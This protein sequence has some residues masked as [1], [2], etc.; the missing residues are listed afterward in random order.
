MAAADLPLERSV[1]PLIDSLTDHAIYRLDVDGRVASWNVGAE[2]LKGYSEAEIRGQ[3]FSRFF[4]LEDCRSR[5]PERLLEEAA[6]EGRVETEG[7]RIR[8]DGSR[9]WAEGVL[10]AVREQ[11]RLVG[12]AKITRDMTGH[13]AAQQALIESERRFRILVEGVLDYA[14]YM[15]DPDGIV[16]NWNRGA[17]R[18]KG[19]AARDV[20]GR[21]FSTFYTP[22]DREAG[23]PA[24]ALAT[25]LSR[26]SFEG[27]GWRLR[28]DGSRFWAMVVIHAV[29]DESGRHIGFAKVTRDISERKA[30]EEALAQSERQFR[31]L[32]GSVVDYAMVMLDPS[33][34]VTN[35]NA[36]AERIKG[37]TADEIVGQ[38]F[39][40]FYTEADRAAGAPNAALRCSREEGRYETE[41]WR[42]RRD[43]TQF[44]ASVVID[45]IR[46]ETGEVIGFAKITR[47]ITERRNAQLELDRAREKAAQGRKLEAL[48]QLTGGVAHDFN[49]L[50]M[51]VGGSV[52]TLRRRLDPQDL[53]TRRALEAIESA[54]LRGAGLTRQL[55]SFAGRQRLD[56][57][58]SPFGE[59]LESLR[60]LVAASLPP[61]IEFIVDAD[62][63]LWPVAVDP[64]E[65][66]L[67]LLNL[68]VNARDAMAAGGRLTLTARNV[69]ATSPSGEG[70]GAHLG[71]HVRLEVRDTGVGIP[72]DIV[73]RIFEPFFTTKAVDKGTGLGLSQVYGFARQSGGEVRVESALGQGT[74][75]TL[76]IP[77]C[78][79]ASAA[80]PAD[81]APVEAER[82][83][84]AARILV[85]E[86][87]PEVA[88][89]A[90]NM[91]EQLGHI[92]R[93]VG[94]AEAALAALQESPAPDVVF[95]DIV[96]AG[97][98]DG[99]GLA[100]LLAERHP[101][102]PVVLAT[103]YAR[104]ADQELDGFDVIRK[105]YRLE[106]LD[107]GLR[108]ALARG[109]LVEAENLVVLD[110]ARRA[111]RKS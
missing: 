57:R 21:H 50:L 15:L 104:V 101:A 63:G 99:L 7:W 1:D 52:E 60:Q 53:R 65:L 9:F 71:E 11:D 67:A 41:G 81:E 44:W 30:A 20:V 69:A 107:R 64:G 5:V 108:R 49:N 42:T 55:L 39:S 80:A 66:D 59:R 89:V 37:Y 14:I 87:N 94:G 83:N 26:G 82:P 91:V 78:E 95:S 74:V 109:R 4:T 43:G 36:G 77:R 58:V 22:D 45:P 18:I 16:T 29:H 8:R 28:K 31:L 86:D 23:L 34:V 33:G 68:A 35:W 47:D 70:A 88:E 79:I 61:T 90:A 27:E 12:F 96:M 51:I 110:T 3:P 24:R 19:Y 56:V 93:V 17:E 100:K 111:R 54:T 97:A 13:R 72:P 46:D 84:R 48:G 76:C 103:G 98:M 40:R 62:E 106:D 6:R 92:P 85:V 38:H 75:F 32:V 102:L 105:P 25:A 2:R 10:H 73:E